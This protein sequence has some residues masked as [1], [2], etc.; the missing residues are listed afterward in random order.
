MLKNEEAW[1][2]RTHVKVGSMILKLMLESLTVSMRLDDERFDEYIYF[3]KYL[4]EKPSW[5]KKYKRG[6]RSKEGISDNDK[7]E[8][9]AET[10]PNN[11][12]EDSLLQSLYP[13]SS[14]NED[15]FAKEHLDVINRLRSKDDQHANLFQRVH[16]KTKLVSD[17]PEQIIHDEIRKVP[18]LYHT[19]CCKNGKRIGVLRLHPKVFDD[20]RSLTNILNLNSAKYKPMVV[21]P[22]P[23]RTSTKGGYLV[24]TL[25][26]GPCK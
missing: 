25:K 7:V 15:D 21:P 5:T 14:T 1:S 11:S 20:L 9:S 6:L 17:I 26:T 16:G 24:C 2:P 10:V 18:A 22:L 19:Y 23:W 8:I 12:K 13:S 4:L 3:E